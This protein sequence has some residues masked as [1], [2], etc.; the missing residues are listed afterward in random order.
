MDNIDS[1]ADEDQPHDVMTGSQD[2]D[3]LE[4]DLYMDHQYSPAPEL[5]PSCVSQYCQVFNVGPQS[6]PESEEE[7]DQGDSTYV[8]FLPD[9]VPDSK[10]TDEDDIICAACFEDPRVLLGE[11][12]HQL[13]VERQLDDLGLSI[14]STV[15]RDNIQVMALK[16]GNQLTQNVFKGIQKLTHGH[17]VIGSEYVRSQMLEDVSGV[18]AQVY[19]CCVN[20]CVCFTRKFDSITTCLLCGEPRV[21]E[22]KKPRNRFRYIPIIPHLQVMFHNWDT[23]NLLLYRLDHGVDRDQIEDVWDGA[24]LRELLKKNVTVDGQI[25]EYTYGELKTDIFLAMTCDGISIHKGIGARRSKTEYACFPIE[26]IIL[27]LPPELQTQDQYVY[28][29]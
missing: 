6:E 8:W 2:N 27:S 14:L 13:D 18:K 22:W 21:N 26:L 25:Q 20:L 7:V 10:D 16:I 5:G 1:R 17:M 9:T 29:E 15:A 23:I 24:V 4:F 19:D 28:S 11:E 3:I 12:S